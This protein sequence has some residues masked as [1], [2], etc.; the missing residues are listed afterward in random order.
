MLA[1]GCSANAT[2]EYCRLGES[3]ALESLCKFCCAI[4]AVYGQWY[5]MS[6]NPTD[7]YRLLHK[8]S[9]RGFPDMLESLDWMYLELKN[10]PST[11]AS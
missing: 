11:W 4:K 9:H 8:A 7:L 5:L 6:L 2:D 10:F 3:T 1:W